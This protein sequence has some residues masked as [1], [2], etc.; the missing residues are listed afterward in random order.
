MDIIIILTALASWLFVTVMVSFSITRF[1]EN[2]M[3][4]RGCAKDQI[5]MFGIHI[6]LIVLFIIGYQYTKGKPYPVGPLAEVCD[7]T[8]GIN[9][10]A[11]LF[12][13]L[14]ITI[15]QLIPQTDE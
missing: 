7:V 1:T 5:L 13:I 11:I 10:A 12:E 6:F 9:V 3:F 4:E 15:E 8:A 2:G 14:C